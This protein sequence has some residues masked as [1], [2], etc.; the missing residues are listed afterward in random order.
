MRHFYSKTRLMLQH[1]TTP[2]V[3]SVLA[4]SL[5]WI[6]HEGFIGVW[7]ASL[8]G[9]GLTLRCS[10]LRFASTRFAIWGDANRRPRNSSRDSGGSR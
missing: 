1:A 8:A 6:L 3:L 10:I 9:V 7:D 5:W 2:V 4:L